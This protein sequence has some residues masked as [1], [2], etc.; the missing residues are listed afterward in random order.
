MMIG[1]RGIGV[2]SRIKQHL[3]Y[4]GIWKQDNHA[5]YTTASI[6][7]ENNTSQTCVYCF[8]KIQHPKQ[9]IPVEGKTVY[10]NMKGALHCL[11]LECPSARNSR[12][13]S[14][15]DKLSA[16]VIAISG[17]TTLL[18]Q[19]TLPAF[20]RTISHSNTDF[21]RKTA[22]FCTRSSILAAREA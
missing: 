12:G 16:L 2:G 4:G 7:N 20:S 22:S 21:N 13:V 10:R 17:I 3:R 9:L 6:I 18:F 1:D 14:G 11:N 8:Q 15:H 5:R 19:Q